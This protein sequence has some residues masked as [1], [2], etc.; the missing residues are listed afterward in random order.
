MVVVFVEVVVIVFVEVVIV[1]DEKLVKVA[2]A[3]VVFQDEG[4]H[5]LRRGFDDG[6][7]RNRFVD[8]ISH[9]C[10]CF[11]CRDEDLI[12]VVW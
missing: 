3:V 5:W 9:I 2:V 7:R 11:S 10:F 1:V 6:S 8:N 4:I 12:V